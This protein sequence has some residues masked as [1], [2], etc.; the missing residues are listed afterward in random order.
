[1]PNTPEYRSEKKSERVWSDAGSMPPGWDELTNAQK[2]VFTQAERLDLRDGEFWWAP[3]APEHGVIGTYNNYYCRCPKCQRA[4]A[5][6]R[7]MTRNQA[8][9]EMRRPLGIERPAPPPVDD[10][11]Y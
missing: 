10:F 2:L 5:D 8:P 9:M 4:N 7:Y 6:Y 1:M 11:S 3:G